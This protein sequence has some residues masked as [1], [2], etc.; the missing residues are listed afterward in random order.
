[1]S[2]PPPTPPQPPDPL[3]AAETAGTAA[4]M[5]TAARRLV[6][7]LTDRQSHLARLPWEHAART[8]WTYL[9]RPRTGVRLLDVGEVARKAAHRLL[10]TALSRHAFAQAVTIMALEEVLDLDEGGRRGRH[11]DDY[12]VVVFGTPSVES[13]AGPWS[14]RLE[15]HHLPVTATLTPQ[16]A[17][18]EV[19][20]APV[21][22][23]ARPARVHHARPGGRL[24]VGPLAAEEDVARELLRALPPALRARA[25]V[26]DAAP[27]DIHTT[28]SAHVHTPV[29]PPGVAGWELGGGAA[30]LL[31]ELTALYVD[32]LAEPL[33]ERGHAR[34]RDAEVFFAWE[35][36]TEPGRPCYHRL[37]A[38]GLL[39]VEYDNTTTGP[40]VADHAH[41][42]LRR[43]GADFGGD[44]RTA[45]LPA[46]HPDA[47][48]GA[49]GQDGRR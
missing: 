49:A 9:P 18:W 29:E 35:G 17:G 37:Q 41:T 12:H 6:A 43:P 25:V 32:R 5:V 20:V 2:G 26:A 15:G 8:R 38:P 44:P 14:W 4:A 47:R 10:A 27:A 7:V 36:P 3:G 24:V 40:G 16:N 28:T 48:A 33:A 22:L 34:L 42:V 19:V 21:F 11:S 1:M 23:G 46:R 39:L 31:A 13:G 45:H 30:E